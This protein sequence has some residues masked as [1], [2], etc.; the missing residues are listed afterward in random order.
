VANEHRV[1][2]IVAQ[3]RESGGK[4]DRLFEHH[5]R[6]AVGGQCFGQPS[7]GALVGGDVQNPHPRRQAAGARHEVFSRAFEDRTHARYPDSSKT[8]R[9]TRP[10]AEGAVP[11]AG[12]ERPATVAGWA[13]CVN[14]SPP[15]PVPRRVAVHAIGINLA[16]ESTEDTA[17]VY[18]IRYFT[19]RTT[20]IVGSRFCEFFTSFFSVCSVPSV[21]NLASAAILKMQ[22]A[23]A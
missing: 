21:A 19:W 14:V 15:C 20:R 22:Q 10:Q 11:P 7:A 6:G 23:K 5:V 9:E 4:A 13:N 3:P 1:E 12:R 2:N 8:V 16:T 17:K 18:E